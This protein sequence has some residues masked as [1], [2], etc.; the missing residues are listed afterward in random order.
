MRDMLPHLFDIGSFH[1]QTYGLLVAVGAIGSVIL[2]ARLAQ[3]QGPNPNIASQLGL[4]A[5][6][7]GVLGAKVLFVVL[8]WSF[9]YQHPAEILSAATLQAGG[10]F[11]GGLLAAL[12]ACAVYIRNHHLPV[13]RT[14]DTFAPALAMGHAI[15]R[16]GCFAAGCCY[17]RSTAHFWGVTF[18]DPLARELSGTPL[19][20]RMEPTQLF[21]AAIEAVNFFIL[22]WMLRK[23]RFDGQ[24][25]GTYLLLYG[26]ARFLLEFLRGDPGRGQFLGSA[27]SGTQLIALCLVMAGGL[28]TNQRLF[29]VFCTKIGVSGQ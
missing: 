15:G 2:S 9:Y 27:M 12:I 5:I 23:K 7:S 16:L 18:T 6:L 25:I 17:G 24:V 29:G 3:T 21:E 26:T 22:L 11:S 8:N 19:G 4:I 14:A 10:V 13:L 20:V 28:I 1:L